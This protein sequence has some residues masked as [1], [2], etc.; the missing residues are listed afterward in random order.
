[1]YAQTISNLLGEED[2]QAPVKTGTPFGFMLF[3]ALAAPET[4][5]GA[6]GAGTSGAMLLGSEAK[7]NQQCSDFLGY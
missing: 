6:V 4:P 1:M 2:G 5:A 7:A 3:L